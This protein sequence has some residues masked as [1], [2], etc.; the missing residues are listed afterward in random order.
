MKIFILNNELQFMTMI[1]LVYYIITHTHTHI[2][3]SSTHTH[4]YTDTP[5]ISYPKHTHSTSTHA[6]NIS[7]QHIDIPTHIHM[8]S[9]VE[10]ELFTRLEY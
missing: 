5:G 10:Q 2:Y 3:P 8:M 1:R 9:L 6:Q 4:I 7:A